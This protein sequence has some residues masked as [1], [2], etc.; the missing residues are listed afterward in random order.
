MRA[1]RRG[2]GPRA[3]YAIYALIGGALVAAARDTVFFAYAPMLLFR[4][5]ESARSS[6]QS[7][8]ARSAAIPT[9]VH[10]SFEQAHYPGR[11]ARRS[12]DVQ[13]DVATAGA[14]ERCRLMYQP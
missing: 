11:I 12:R 2:A 6:K 13:F 14:G 4:A 8:K 10:A 9:C 3:I 1:M 5:A 7:T